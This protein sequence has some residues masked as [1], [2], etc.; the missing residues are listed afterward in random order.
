MKKILIDRNDCDYIAEGLARLLE[1]K[2]I[3]EEARN[4]INLLWDDITDMLYHNNE[5]K[6]L[7]LKD[8]S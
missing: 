8:K 2:Y 6:I 7:V 4:E 3:T 5:F 1:E